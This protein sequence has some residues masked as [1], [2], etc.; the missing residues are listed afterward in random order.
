MQQP[1][2]GPQ[3]HQIQY[4]MCIPT[5]YNW[6]G[7]STT[8]NVNPPFEIQ[9]HPYSVPMAYNWQGSS[10]AQNLSYSIASHSEHQPL[11]TLPPVSS[12]S[13]ITG[14]QPA[15]QSSLASPM[16][17]VSTQTGNYLPSSAVMQQSLKNFEE[18][19]RNNYKLCTEASA[20]TLCQILAKEVFFGKDV[21]EQC[22]PNGASDCPGLPR[23]ELN[24]PKAAMFR[25]F[26]RFHSCPE[27]FEPL[28]KKCM[29]AMEQAC[30]RLRLAK[31]TIPT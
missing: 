9:Q 12:R 16:L 18:V 27:L 4:D 21:M 29:V 7:P 22:T 20:G 11:A 3:Q 23:Q 25:L 1:A 26:P 6:Q 19:L 28:W 10:G 17:A 8:Q 14:S 2:Y 31:R 30:R 24:N 13:Q 5:P 15:N